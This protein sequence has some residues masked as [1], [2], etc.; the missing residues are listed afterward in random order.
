MRSF[1]SE[2]GRGSDDVPRQ[3]ALGRRG[4]RRDVIVFPV[5]VEIARGDHAEAA[6]FGVLKERSQGK[7]KGGE[8]FIAK[9]VTVNGIRDGKVLIVFLAIG[10]VDARTRAQNGVAVRPGDAQA[11]VEIGV[12]RMKEGIGARA[13]SPARAEIE[14]DVVI[15]DGVE[16][17]EKVVAYSG[18]DGQVWSGFPFVLNVAEVLRLPLPRQRQDC[19]VRRRTHVVV[20]EGRC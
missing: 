17:I 5:A 14:R 9:G 4:P 19:G 11:R 20:Q 16:R 10:M 15:T 3:F 2:I 1:V 7:R 18:G 12:A 8:C 13:V 6:R